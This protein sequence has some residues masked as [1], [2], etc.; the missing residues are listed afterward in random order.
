MKLIYE[1]NQSC[2]VRISFLEIDAQ[3]L[4][5][6][7]KI[8]IV[9]PLHNCWS[10]DIRLL[11][12]NHLADHSHQFTQLMAMISQMIFYNSFIFCYIHNCMIWIIYWKDK[13]GESNTPLQQQLYD[14]TNLYYLK[15][16]YF[17]SKTRDPAV[18][19]R[20]ARPN[21]IDTWASD[22]H[23]YKKM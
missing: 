3:N 22:L 10:C 17:T 19:P 11:E 12:E 23:K 13:T 9:H 7:K 18:T 20:T 5:K 15:S 4:S 2:K 16:A 6:C 1:D 8:F 21:S 14:S